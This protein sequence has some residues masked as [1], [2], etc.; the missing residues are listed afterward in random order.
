MSLKQLLVLT[1]LISVFQA[2]HTC[3]GDGTCNNVAAGL[4]AFNCV[5]CDS[6][7]LG[8]ECG[9]GSAQTD[10]F[11]CMYDCKSNGVVSSGQTY[12]AQA[13]HVGDNAWYS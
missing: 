2:T 5:S 7:M 6:V 10:I 11:W 4:T 8:V 12:E 13:A 9:G 1:W 3:L